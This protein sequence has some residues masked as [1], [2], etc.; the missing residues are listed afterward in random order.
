MDSTVFYPNWGILCLFF[1]W[2]INF[3]INFPNKRLEKIGFPFRKKIEKKR[4]DSIRFGCLQVL[5]SRY[6]WIIVS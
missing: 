4:L 1:M 3:Q 6:T 2:E 5:E